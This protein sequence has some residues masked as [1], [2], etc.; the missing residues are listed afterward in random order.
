MMERYITVLNLSN[1]G[2]NILGKQIDILYDTVRYDTERREF[3]YGSD[4]EYSKDN[5]TID[6]DFLSKRLDLMLPELTPR[7]SAKF[8]VEILEETGKNI[9]DI[10]EETEDSIKAELNEHCIELIDKYKK[11]V[12]DRLN[13]R[14]RKKYGDNYSIDNEKL[15]EHNKEM[16]NGGFT[17][18]SNLYYDENKKL[19]MVRNG[20]IQLVFDANKLSKINRELVEC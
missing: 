13:K 14:E 7:E 16:Y 5:Y 8:H 3:V 17:V 2:L 9:E 12:A 6:C 1:H 18:T 4:K 19:Y 15:R 10:L 11:K 20:D